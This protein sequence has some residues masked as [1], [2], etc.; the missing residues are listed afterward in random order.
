MSPTSV[1][2]LSAYYAIVLSQHD[3]VTQGIHKQYTEKP[4]WAARGDELRT[5]AFQVSGN[6]ITR[7]A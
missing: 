3:K 1:S 6:A 5:P 4:M 2:D 7:V